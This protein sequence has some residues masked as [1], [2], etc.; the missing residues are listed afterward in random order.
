MCV[1]VRVQGQVK[2]SECEYMSVIVSESMQVCTGECEG[3]CVCHQHV[4][5]RGWVCMC[6]SV[7]VC[8]S[9]S[10]SV[11]ECVG[12]PR[13]PAS[14]GEPGLEL[15][16][17]GRQLWAHLPSSGV[18]AQDPHSRPP[19]PQALGIFPLVLDIH[20]IPAPNPDTEAQWGHGTHRRGKLRGGDVERPG[21]VTC[22]GNVGGRCC[23]EDGCEHSVFGHCVG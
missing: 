21:W 16:G 19:R 9:V 17:P 4:N 6:V 2:G 1:D 20:S 13:P 14:P 3:Q 18:L 10:M 8:V 23:Q 7:C 15:P 22:A 5:V 12:R 11:C